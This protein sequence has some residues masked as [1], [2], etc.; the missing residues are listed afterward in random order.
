MKLKKRIAGVFFPWVPFLSLKL[1]KN[2]LSQRR[3]MYRCVT[4]FTIFQA[5]IQIWDQVKFIKVTK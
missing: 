1:V 5:N 4:S 2:Y 3:H